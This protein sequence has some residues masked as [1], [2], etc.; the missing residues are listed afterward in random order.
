MP[1]INGCVTTDPYAIPADLS[2]RVEALGLE[3]N[4]RELVEQG[5]TVVR[6][7]ASQALTDGLRQVIPDKVD[8]DPDAEIQFATN[9]LAPP[10]E[11][12]SYT[13][14]GA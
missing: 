1:E 14:C 5:F 6:N 4:V 12:R 13:I 3:E 8:T 7:D 11:H 10:Q 2:Q 9:M